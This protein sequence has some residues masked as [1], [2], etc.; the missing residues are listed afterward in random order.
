[1]TEAQIAELRAVLATALAPFR[2]G[3][4]ERLSILTTPLCASGR[5]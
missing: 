4:G 1:M 5:K 2:T 3:T